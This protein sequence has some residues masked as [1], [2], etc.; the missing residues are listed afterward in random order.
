ME[1]F[2]QYAGFLLR[3]VTVVVAI[4]MVLVV[5]AAL[6]SK[7]RG[8]SHGQLQ[9][10]KLNDVYQSLR[11]RLEQAVLDKHNLKIQ[12]KA[13]AKHAKQ[14]KKEGA[15]KPRVFVLDFDGDIKASATERTTSKVNT[16]PLPNSLSTRI[17]PP[18]AS[19]LS[20]AIPRPKPVPSRI[21]A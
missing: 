4:V 2:A 15:K 19:A 13:E 21:R 1:F 14:A 5:I 7:G 12:R 17:S 9:V 20:L 8:Q 18:S 16:L 3:T 11:E 6:R 10:H